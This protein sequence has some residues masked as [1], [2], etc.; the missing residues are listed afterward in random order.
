MERSEEIQ[1]P[2]IGMEVGYREVPASETQG[3]CS[4]VA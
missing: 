1:L 4:S 3:D 2:S